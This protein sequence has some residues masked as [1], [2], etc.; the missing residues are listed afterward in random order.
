MDRRY[1]SPF[2]PFLSILTVYGCLS[3]FT[4]MHL[5][6]KQISVILCSCFLALSSFNALKINQSITNINR[7]YMP[8]RT[9]ISGKTVFFYAEENAVAVHNFFKWLQ[10][11]LPAKQIYWLTDFCTPKT[12]E[13][14]KDNPN[15]YLFVYHKRDQGVNRKN[16]KIVLTDKLMNA[17]PEISAITSKQTFLNDYFI[18]TVNEE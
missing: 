10:I 15:A 12:I 14:L 16:I 7:A 18:Y 17:C 5:S 4:K 9:D 1:F 6:T 13:L 3:L 8:L 11:I 2:F